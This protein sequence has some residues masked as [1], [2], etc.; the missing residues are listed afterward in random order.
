M[1]AD[2]CGIGGGTRRFSMLVALYGSS[3]RCK[4]ESV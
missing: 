4:L 1:V 2:G 3:E